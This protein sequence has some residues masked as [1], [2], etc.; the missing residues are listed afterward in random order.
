MTSPVERPPNKTLM[1]QLVYS[2]VAFFA[3][4]QCATAQNQWAW[5][6][7]DKSP[8]LIS[9]YGTR[10]VVASSNIPGSRIGMA[11]WTDSDGN[12]W[13]FGGNGKGES[14]R[15]GYLN[16]LWKYIPASGM[17]TWIGGNK[18]TNNTGSYNSKGSPSVNNLPGARMNA[19]TWKDNNG[20]FWLFGGEGMVSQKEKQTG[21]GGSTTDGNGTGGNT[22]GGNSGNGENGNNGNGD[23]GNGNGDD[24]HSGDKN[25]NNGHHGEGNNGNGNGNGGSGRNDGHDVELESDDG[26]LNDLWMFSPSTN[27]WTF[28]GGTDKLNER[29]EYGP[30]GETSAGTYPGARSQ[31]SGWTDNNGNL[32]LF[33]G[34]GYTSKSNVSAL[35]DV[36]KYST[37]NRQWTW[38]NGSKNGNDIAH[39]GDKGVFAADNLPRGRHGSATWSDGDGNLWMFGGGTNTELYCD[40][41]KYN[42]QSNQ[43]A[44]IS[45]SKDSDHAPVFKGK[46]IPDKDGN[47]GARMMAAGWVD[48]SGNLWLFGG[49]GYGRQTGTSFVNNL[50][51]YD[52]ATGTWTFVKGEAE[53]LSKAEYGN[54]G[55]LSNANNPAGTAN[56]AS[57]K[58]QQGNFWLFGGQSSAGFLN[59]IWKFAPC[60]NSISGTRYN[61]VIL[62]ANTPVQLNARTIGVAYEWTPA[63]G[64]NN[65]SSPTPLVTATTER[66]YIVT[67]TTD[68]GCT[69]ND[70]VLV[71][72]GTSEKKAVVVPTAF[73]PDGNGVNDRLRPLGNLVSLDY[74]RIFNRWGAM[75]YQTT[76]WGTGWDGRYK[77]VAQPAETYTWVLSGK[78]ADGQ[79]L[80][81]SGKTLLIR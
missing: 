7:G 11:T 69:T 81:L 76:E 28:V 57:W 37:G 22:G 14:T 10:G 34:S 8:N 68:Q 52:V 5:I 74:F 80:K 48:A 72:I 77:G 50:W 38:M 6:S 79:T 55:E 32:W 49:S 19:V 36:W 24:D 54:K 47:P 59:Q 18:T 45:G 17:W 53:V 3:V 60:A 44:W 65:P 58:D 41:W 12:L 71:K 70:T 62:P 9:N 23:N 42:S 51:K 27:E 15:S 35:N 78:T 13:L 66:E 46:G 16:D 25:G 2:F 63:I 31:A 20:N 73:T 30:L 43:W 33:G 64:L 4:V 26:L 56:Y 29:G 67:I 75:L 21:G 61:D 40:L 1:K 39:F